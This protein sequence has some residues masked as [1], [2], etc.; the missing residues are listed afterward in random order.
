MVRPWRRM[1]DRVL[2]EIKNLN[3]RTLVRAL[4][5]GLTR[6]DGLLGYSSWRDQIAEHFL[7]HREGGYLEIR[8]RLD[9]SFRRSAEPNRREETNKIVR[10]MIQSLHWQERN[11]C[12]M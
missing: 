5:L 8:L 7:L 6:S 9:L 10:D 12:N 1:L 11:K 4:R 2:S 3:P